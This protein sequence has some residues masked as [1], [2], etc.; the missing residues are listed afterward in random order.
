[1]NQSFLLLK[2]N[3]IRTCKKVLQKEINKFHKAIQYILTP[4]GDTNNSYIIH[5]VKDYMLNFTRAEVSFT[6][7]IIRNSYIIENE[8][9][10]K[11]LPTVYKELTSLEELLQY[12]HSLNRIRYCNKISNSNE[13]SE[14]DITEFISFDI[15]IYHNKDIIYEK[16]FK[17]QLGPIDILERIKDIYN[18]IVKEDKVL[19]IRDEKW[20]IDKS[21][22]KGSNLLGI[23]LL[24]TKS[25]QFFSID[26]LEILT[27]TIRDV[28]CASMIYN[29]NIDEV[30]IIDAD[31]ISEYLFNSGSMRF[32]DLWSHVMNDYLEYI[33]YLPTLYTNLITCAELMDLSDSPRIYKIKTSIMLTLFG[34]RENPTYEIVSTSDETPSVSSFIETIYKIYRGVL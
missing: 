4:I 31:Y 1:M 19:N 21:P 8:T 5:K 6:P 2:D 33:T 23:P 20:S 30:D 3:T 17:D 24:Y 16:H 9:S 11:L 7:L 29:P 15:V 22:M 26:I 13:S 27:S 25:Y 28:Y 34:R 12:L 18:P 32:H 14:Y 10:Y